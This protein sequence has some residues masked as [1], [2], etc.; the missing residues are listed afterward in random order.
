ML[1]RMKYQNIRFF[2]VAKKIILFSF[3]TICIPGTVLNSK[4]NT[5]YKLRGKTS[6]N[7]VVY[8]RRVPR[9]LYVTFVC[10]CVCV[11]IFVDHTYRFLTFIII[12]EIYKTKRKV[13]YVCT[14]TLIRSSPKLHKT[15]T[16]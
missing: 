13:L 6:K 5:R 1:I 3:C 4:L 15:W 9:W 12:D 10:V 16:A 7:T 11:Y 14:D 2:L 8:A